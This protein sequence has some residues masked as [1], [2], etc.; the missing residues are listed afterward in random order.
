MISIIIPVYN[1]EKVIEKLITHLKKNS[2]D[3]FVEIIV[4]DGGS[5]DNTSSIVLKHNIIF[6]K[7]KQKGRAKQMNEAA[8]AS[9]G[10]ILHFIHADTLP[11]KTF[12]EDITNAINAG[13]DFGRFCLKFDSA[14][15]RLKFNAYF[16]RFDMFECCG[17]DQTLFITKKM[18]TA[19]NGF[20]DTKL[21]MEDFDI[22][23][24]A[25]KIGR[26]KIIKKPVLVSARKYQNNGWLKVQKANYKMIKLY[27]KN[28]DQQVMVDTY[29]KLLQPK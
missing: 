18:F 25:K 9:K 6:F 24:R 28:S 27:K 8:A 16:S 22:F 21:I 4:A 17:G 13:Y 26:H 10:D 1:E 2:L 11:P 19:L 15:V 20:D 5:T 14:D 7:C 3:N 12:T 29:K 23:E